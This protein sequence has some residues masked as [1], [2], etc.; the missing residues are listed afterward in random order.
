MD[1]RSRGVTATMEAVARF[2]RLGRGG[3]VAAVVALLCLVAGL[4]YFAVAWQ[5]RRERLRASGPIE[6]LVPN[7]SRE[8]D[9]EPESRPQPRSLTSLSVEAVQQLV[10]AMMAAPITPRRTETAAEDEP[11]R[12]HPHPGPALPDVEALAS[13]V[14][15][16][17][18]AINDLAAQLASPSQLAPER[19]ARPAAV[20]EPE[21]PAP[22]ADVRVLPHAD[23]PRLLVPLS[24]ETPCERPL[25][26]LR[27]PIEH[28][29]A[30][31]WPSDEELDRFACGYARRDTP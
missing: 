17:T 26:M 20:E 27:D 11:R 8:P 6:R 21:R 23:V 16:L 14:A 25:V 9:P 31:A 29:D 13:Q 3:V 19:A 15:A 10:E 7:E 12:A 30:Y 2:V 28:S 22:V 5:A 4:W 24:E 18:A 1:L